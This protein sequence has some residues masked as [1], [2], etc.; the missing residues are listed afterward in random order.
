MAFKMAS[1][2]NSIQSKIRM[3]TKDVVVTLSKPKAANRRP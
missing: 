1:Q 2:C 3:I